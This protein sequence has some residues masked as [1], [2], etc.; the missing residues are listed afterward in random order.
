MEEE[1]CIYIII[2]KLGSAYFVFVST[3]YSMIEALGKAYQK[4]ILESFC[5]ALIREKDK[6]VCYH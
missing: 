3:F 4:P 5:D 6:R 2:S 1:R